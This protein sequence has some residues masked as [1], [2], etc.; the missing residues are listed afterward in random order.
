[1]RQIAS[2]DEVGARR[3]VDYLIASGIPAELRPDDDSWD[4]WVEDDDDL[5]RARTELEAFQRA[6][7]DVRY[8]GAVDEADA[9]EYESP[10]ETNSVE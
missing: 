4:V 9:I 8:T 3:F 10:P 1:M 2:L 6:P 5:D 7:D